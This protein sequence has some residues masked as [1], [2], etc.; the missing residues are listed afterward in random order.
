M[1]YIKQAVAACWAVL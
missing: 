1:N